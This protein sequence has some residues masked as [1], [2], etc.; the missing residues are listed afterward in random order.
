LTCKSARSTLTYTHL[1][2]CERYQIQ[3]LLRNGFSQNRI[4]AE[5]NRAPST[6]AR[7]V[8]RAG[9]TLAYQAHA[10]QELALKRQLL[11]RNA[12][13]IPPERWRVVQAYL[14][15]YL[16]PE[17]ICGRLKLERAHSV[18]PES[19]YAYVYSDKAK[20]GDLVSYLR[21]QKQRRKRYGSAQQRRGQIKGR[22]CIEQRPAVVDARA[23][24]GDWEG[25]TVIGRG[26][27]GVLVTLVERHSRF[28]LAQPLPSKEAQ[29]VSEAIRQML[30]PHKEQCLTITFDNGHEFAD[31]AFFGQ[32]LGADVYFAHPYHSWERGTNE[33]TNGL[34]RQYFPKKMSFLNLSQIEV[35]DAIHLLNHR[36]R[37]CIGYRTPHEVFYGLEMRPLN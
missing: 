20:G 33:N 30:R 22:V 16:S 8:K 12:R 10:A 18:S 6:I 7:E 26:H 1:T 19:I 24:I 9:P 5:L 11:S 29:P 14:L 35:D 13:T 28:A 15:L 23:R 2:Q 34:L 25:D 36:P 21:C 37:K 27:S 32:C 3:L 4:A 31:H 17:Q